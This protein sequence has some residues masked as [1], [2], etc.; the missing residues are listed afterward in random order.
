M[1]ISL[2]AQAVGRRRR[3][4]RERLY[5]KLLINIEPGPDVLSVGNQNRFVFSTAS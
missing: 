4:G 5:R 2:K 3:R 1:G